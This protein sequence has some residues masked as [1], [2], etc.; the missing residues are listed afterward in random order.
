M[1]I[2]VKRVITKGEGLEMLLILVVRICR[3]RRKKNSRSLVKR[4]REVRLFGLRG[5]VMP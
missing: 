2:R 4:L 3:E 5:L 1:L